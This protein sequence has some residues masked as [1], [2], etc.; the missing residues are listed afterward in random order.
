MRS[1][2]ERYFF[3]LV[4]TMAITRQKKEQIL[5]ELIDSFKNAK[6][7]VF[8]HYKGTS[9]KD[10]G[11]LR[12]KLRSEQVEFKVAK[13]TLIQRAAKEAGMEEIPA[14]SMDGPIGLAIAMGDEI[15][16]ARIIHDFGKDHE[17]VAITG[18]WFES[19]MMNAADAKTLATLPT[20]EQLLGQLVGLM[21]SPVAGFHGVLN[22]VL[23][24]FVRVCS[25]LEK[26]GGAV[27]V[28][29]VSTPAPAAEAAAETPSEEA[30]KSE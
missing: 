9:V 27:P 15:A 2:I 6:S 5:S 25:E 24:G 18:A 11:E 29:A 22:N 13:K 30:P 7:V 1:Q 3:T 28:E 16:P 12:N 8:S 21:M 19:K 10:I 26:K 4:H 23:T 17:T 14:G 20:R